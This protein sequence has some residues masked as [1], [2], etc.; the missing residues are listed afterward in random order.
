MLFQSNR[1]PEPFRISLVDYISAILSIPPEPV[2]LLLPPP[3]Q[4][5]KQQQHH[6]TEQHK[7]AMPQPTPHILS[8]HQYVSKKCK[9]PAIFILHPA[10]R[11]LEN[12]SAAAV[13]TASNSIPSNEKAE[14]DIN[15]PL[16]TDE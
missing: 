8:F 1:C 2:P 13:A 9:I 6:L 16:T 11:E 4:T 10:F 15:I 5:Y 12:A 3:G 14:D 7:Q